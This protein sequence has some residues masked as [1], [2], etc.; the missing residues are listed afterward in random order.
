MNQE[1]ILKDQNS[2][3]QQSHNLAIEI[4][5]LV[6]QFPKFETM[7]MTLSLR[8]LS[9]SVVSNISKGLSCKEYKDFN[10]FMNYAK[11]SS[12][13]IR[14]LS[15]MAKDIGY[16]TEEQLLSIENKCNL[17]FEDIK[18]IIKRKEIRYKVNTKYKDIND[19]NI[20]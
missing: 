12:E 15:L 5:T 16:I 7:V 19:S 11:A 17:F 8:R 14:S 3:K 18:K 9:L 6:L 13:A 1:A 20:N 4:Y 10:F 2:L